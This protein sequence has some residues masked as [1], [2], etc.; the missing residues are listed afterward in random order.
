MRITRVE[1]FLLNSAGASLT[2]YP[3]RPVICRVHTD[4]GISG[5]GEAGISTGVGE[6]AVFGML[7]DMAPLFI[8]RDPMDNEVLW[9]ELRE[10][11]CGHI[12]GGG[13]VVFSGMSAFDSAL[14]DIKGKAL[15]VPVYRL[16][17]GKHNERLHCYA[18]QVQQGWNGDWGPR[19][20][21]KEYADTCKAVMRDGFDAVKINFLSFDR[22]RSPIPRSKTMGPLGPE[23]YALVEERLDAIREACGKELRIIAELFCLTDVVSAANL[24]GILRRYNVLFAEEP[25]AT[26]NLEL[27]EVLA[28]RMKTP[29]STG[30]R[31][32]TRWGF[33]QLLRHN[34]VAVIQPDIG[35]CGGISEAK[36][37]CDLAQIYDVRAQMHVCGSPIAEAAAF[38]VEAAIAN[39]YIHELL[40]L[41]PYLENTEYG[42]HCYRAVNGYITVPDRPGIGQELSEKSV[43]E[44]IARTTVG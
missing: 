11:C 4:E 42:E 5:V 37:I 41:S 43:R 35:N 39:F 25:T 30:E 14:M 21:A 10:K 12:S 29:L 3:I 31:L 27:F 19:G 8:G 18:S 34:A 6:H 26:F 24:D 1:I 28:G 15:G 17:G 22:D 44:A 38:Q 16:L 36:K 9:E 40:F 20:S 2:A 23:V 13:V 32:H 7:Q 33:H